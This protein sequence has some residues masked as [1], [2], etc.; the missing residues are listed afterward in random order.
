MLMQAEL[1]WLLA[2]V[3]KGDESA[4]E[5]LYEATRALLYGV[6]LRILGRPE[7]AEEVMQET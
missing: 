7:L 2:A 4:F 3:A 6:V 5:R 1:V